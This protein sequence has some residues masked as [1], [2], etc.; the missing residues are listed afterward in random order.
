[1]R[2][3]ITFI[4]FCFVFPSLVFSQD[5]GCYDVNSSYNNALNGAYVKQHIREGVFAKTDWN[6]FALASNIPNGYYKKYGFDRSL[7][8][9]EVKMQGIV[10]NGLQEGLWRLFFSEKYFLV[11]NYINGKKEGM[12]A[13]T[14]INKQ[15]D[16][17]CLSEVEFVNNLYDG[18]MKDY[19]SDGELYKLTSY[20]NGL[21]HG[22]EIEYFDIDTSEVKY[23]ESLKEYSNGKLDGKYLL[24]NYFNPLDT[25]AYGQYSLGKKNG[26]FIYHHS[27]EG[28]T[29]VDFVNDKVEGKLIK[30][31]SNGVLAYELDYKNNLP[32]NLIQTQDTSGNTIELNILTEG[33]GKLSCYDDNGALLSS[34]EY[35]NQLISGKIARY[36]ESGD[37]MEEGLIYTN[38]QKSFGK[39]TPIEKCADL[40]SFSVWQLNFTAG[41]NFTSYNEDGSISTKTLSSFN[42]SI[43]EYIITRENYESEKLIIKEIFWRGLEFG[44]VSRYS[45]DGTLEMTSNYIISDSDSNKTSVKSGPFKYYHPNGI[46]KAEGNY[47]DGNEVGSTYFYDDSGILK[48]VKVIETNGGVYNIYENDTLNRIDYEGRKQGKWIS[49]PHAY[50]ENS[51]YSNPDQIIYYKNDNPTGI[52]E[53][54]SY[55]GIRLI[56]RL[57]WHDS[58]NS[59]S[60][61]WGYNGNLIAEGSMINEIRNG[62]WKEFDHKKGY[63]K[64]KG[65]YSCGK[66]EGIWQKFKRNGKMIKEI[67]Y[68]DGQI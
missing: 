7:C 19:T 45:N 25:S 66:K 39:T 46:V 67:E 15:G 35:N 33:T 47:S 22:Q 16:S 2:Y 17:I 60:Q 51:C 57:V 10:E 20:K 61:T 27:G 29:I 26:R 30:Y 58:V 11:G 34:V 28:R 24:Y 43:G 9:Q 49:I 63:L 62:E 41:T 5:F 68:V 64:F 18:V 36:Y 52:W 42:D 32:Y 37:L 55:D 4:L 1:M 23:I 65:Q 12:W 31:F 8:S 56:E 21:N 14:W 38:T 44:Q 40:N 48:R 59:Y 54:Y 50:S 3:S 6:E 53:Y 13:G